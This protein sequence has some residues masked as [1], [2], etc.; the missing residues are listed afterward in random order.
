MTTVASADPKRLAACASNIGRPYRL[1]EPSFLLYLEDFG[2]R[3]AQLL[4]VLES[5]ADFAV[6][7]RKWM[8]RR[9]RGDPVVVMSQHFL[10]ED[11]LSGECFF[12]ELS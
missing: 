10:S 7:V 3:F 12:Q 11:F 8:S 1:Q 6:S 2:L 5:S 9:F 4:H